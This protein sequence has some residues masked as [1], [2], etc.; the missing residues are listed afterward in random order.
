MIDVNRKWMSRAICVGQPIT[1]FFADNEASAVP[2]AKTSPSRGGNTKRTWD[3][4]RKLCAVCPVLWDCRRDTVGET[5]GYW[6]GRNP[7]ERAHVRNVRSRMVQDL[8]EQDKEELSSIIVQMRSEFANWTDVERV[9]GLKNGACRWLEKWHHDKHPA[10][11]G[12]L[13]EPGW[14]NTGAVLQPE[15][16]RMWELH[17]L[18][19]PQDEIGLRLGR[20]RDTVIRHLRKERD[21]RGSTKASAG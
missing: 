5:H 16:T 21:A 15:R 8:P 13:K 3:A 19:V 11:V 4:A 10:P 14:R 2:H 18:G 1:T 7:N 9:V 17:L 20:A 12:K 6:G